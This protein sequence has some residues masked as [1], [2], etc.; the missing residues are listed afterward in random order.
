[1]L[2][3]T[4][5]GRLTPDSLRR[6]KAAPEILDLALPTAIRHLLD[7]WTERSH[8]NFDVPLTR[9]RCRLP[10]PAETTLY[11]VLQEA[12]TSVARRRA[13]WACSARAGG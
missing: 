1:M 10:A 7:A 6:L 11:H 13:G 2:T 12:V 4:P 9:E 5:W 8:L 3:A